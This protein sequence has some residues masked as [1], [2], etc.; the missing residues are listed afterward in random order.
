MARVSYKYEN[1][2]SPYFQLCKQGFVASLSF[3][4]DGQYIAELDGW[5]GLSVSQVDSNQ[6]DAIIKTGQTE[7]RKNK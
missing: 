2:V 1:T 7:S 4:P 6:L 5:G 3:N